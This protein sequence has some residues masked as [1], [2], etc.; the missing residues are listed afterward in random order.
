MQF[1]NEY[2][3]ELEFNKEQTK[4]KRQKINEECKLC[5]HEIVSTTLKCGHTM[6][7]E[8]CI[9]HFRKSEK[10][11]FCRTMI[12]EKEDRTEEYEHIITSDLNT[13]YLYFDYNNKSM[14]MYDFLKFKGI[15]KQDANE[16]LLCIEDRCHEMFIESEK[17]S[18]SLFPISEDDNHDNSHHD[19]ETSSD[20]DDDINDD[21]NNINNEV[22]QK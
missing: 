11:P 17:Y 9:K 6:C 19:Y 16:I 15:N 12:C 5:F 8:C 3:I 2:E 7:S 1:N 10:C 14:S 18:E 4:S 21:T 20:S 13:K 22:K